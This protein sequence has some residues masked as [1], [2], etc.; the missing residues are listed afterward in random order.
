MAIGGSLADMS[1]DDLK[2]IANGN[3]ETGYYNTDKWRSAATAELNRRGVDKNAPVIAPD[4]IPDPISADAH[5]IAMSASR[6]AA[7]IVKNL[8]I[9]FV[10]LPFVVGVVLWVLTQK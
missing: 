10:L 3:P 5:F 4:P 2:S 6:D 8:W 1:D 9:I 7:R